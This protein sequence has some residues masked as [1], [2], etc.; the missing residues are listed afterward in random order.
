MIDYGKI[1]NPTVVNDI[2]PSGIRRFFDIAAS[3]DDVIS[4]GVGEPDF[5]TPW[6]IRRAGIKSLENSKTRAANSCIVDERSLS[7]FAADLALLW[8]LAPIRAFISAY[9]ISA[10]VSD[11]RHPYSAML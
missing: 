3:M 5:P 2:K 11:F 7:G 10:F 4:L 8:Y 9:T 1:L 6:H